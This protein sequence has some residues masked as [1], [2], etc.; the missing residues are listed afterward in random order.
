MKAFGKPL[1]AEEEKEMLKRLGQGD[2]EARN[3]LVER[4]MR[5]VAHIAKKYSIGDWDMEDLISIGTIGLIKGINSFKQDKNIK[6]A[7]YAAKCI[8]NEILMMLRSEKR[9]QG[10]V[11][12]YD[13]VGKDKE[14]NEIN[15]I[16]V[17]SA[18]SPDIVEDYL[19]D[20][21]IQCIQKNIDKVL[22]NREKMIIIKRYGLTG[23]DAVA[24]SE[25]ATEIGIS[26]SY[27]SRIEKRA[28]EK[29][30]KLLWECG[31]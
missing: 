21:R 25:L 29:L 13:P 3:I 31:L 16:D 9:R 28:L 2:A 19:R 8:D 23:E 30:K 4:N 27:V 24:Q 22:T 6:L 7:T 15:I 1:S 17:V 26:R 12:I 18:E 14:G 20:E 5:L 11:S 10:D